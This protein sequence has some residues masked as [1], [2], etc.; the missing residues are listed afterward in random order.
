LRREQ[1]AH[2]QVERER[3]RDQD[4]E[5]VGQNLEQVIHCATLTLEVMAAPRGRMAAS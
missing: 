2:D 3:G 5:T 4:D 1:A